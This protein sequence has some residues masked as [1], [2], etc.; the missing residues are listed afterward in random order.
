LIREPSASCQLS[1]RWQEAE[2]H[3]REHGSTI[4]LCNA[5]GRPI[6]EGLSPSVKIADGLADKLLRLEQQFGMTPSA[7]ASLGILLATQGTHGTGK[8][9]TKDKTRFFHPA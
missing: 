6:G 9:A 3:I 2:G 7:R 1:L 5:E 8:D 4:S